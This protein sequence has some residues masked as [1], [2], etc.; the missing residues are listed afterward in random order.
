MKCAATFDDGTTCGHKAVSGGNVCISH[1]GRRQERRLRGQRNAGLVQEEIDAHLKNPDLMDVRRPVAMTEALLARTPLFATE[2]MAEVVAR[3]RIAKEIGHDLIR[4]WKAQIRAVGRDEDGDLASAMHEALMS[5]LAPTEGDLDEATLL[6]HERSERI[7][8][9]HRKG[10]VEA[11]KALEW[12]KVM[13]ERLTPVLEE[14][15]MRTATLFRKHVPSHQVTAAIH[16]YQEM[17]TR[18]LGELQA[19]AQEKA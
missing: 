11:V 3:R 10:Q 13:R 18:T 19:A 2:D 14:L 16:D 17:V 9:S 12:A 1:G 8:A 7:I 5:L 15:S 4:A 6:L